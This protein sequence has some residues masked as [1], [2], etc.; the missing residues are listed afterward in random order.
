MGI[1]TLFSKLAEE[2]IADLK[3]LP[4]PVVRLSGPLTTGGFGYEENAKR[5]EKAE[6]VLKNR[7]LN[8][9][10]YEPYE[11]RIYAVYDSSMHEDVMTLFHTPILEIGLIKEAYFLPRWEE[12]KGA[13]YEHELCKR[14][15]ITVKAFEESWF[16][17]KQS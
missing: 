14:L 1:K 3:R 13:S 15:G 5:F 4:Q 9:F 8:V 6:A 16:R 17:T 12:S 10:S 7:G 11:D 2:A